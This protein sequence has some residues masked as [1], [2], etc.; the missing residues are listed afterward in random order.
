MAQRMTVNPS[1]LQCPNFALP[2]F[3]AARNALINDDT[4]Q[5]QAIDRLRD[6]WTVFNIGER[7]LWQQQVEADELQLQAQRQEEDNDRALQLA[8]AQQAKEAEK[9]EERKTNHFKYLPFPDRPI[10]AT[11]MFLPSPFATRKI[12]KG[13]YC[14]LWY[15]T[16]DGLLHARKESR[17][18]DDESMSL[19]ARPDGSYSWIPTAAS[20]DSSSVKDDR[21]LSWEEF[22]IA[23]PRIITAM[24]AASW[25]E[26]RV[27][28]F[29]TFWGS[30]QTH[31]YRSSMDPLDQR[32]LLLYQDEQRRLWHNT[33]ENPKLAHSLAYIDD[34]IL[35]KAKD[36]LFW[37]DR[38]KMSFQLDYVRT[39]RPLFF[40]PY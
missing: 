13:L 21:H 3:A 15:F 36:K 4:N 18:V 23:V 35:A 27:G 2:V 8:A 25:P 30:L 26:D 34:R 38:Q 5:Q 37:E 6:Q 7:A 28:M 32:A 22:S 24:E 31:E 9:A 1:L 14:E 20:R 12:A 10:P 16:N 19:A 17:S 40:C 39:L 33:L 29:V 11:P